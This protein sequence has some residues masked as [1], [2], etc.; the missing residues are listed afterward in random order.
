MSNNDS[1]LNLSRKNRLSAEVTF[2]MLKGAGYAAAVVAILWISL[3]LMGWFGEAVLPAESRTT[4]DPAPTA[5]IE[6]AEREA[7][8]AVAEEPVAM[9]EEG[10]EADAAVTED[11][12]AEAASE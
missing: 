5:F 9:E 12:A 7:A 1:M 11:G 10:A 8:P 4:P 3:A 6:W 2:L